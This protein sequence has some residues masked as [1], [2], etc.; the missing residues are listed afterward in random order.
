M[1]LNSEQAKGA[2][3]P[4][5]N[6]PPLPSAFSEAPELFTRLSQSEPLR[7]VVL[8]SLILNIL[9]LRLSILNKAFLKNKGVLGFLLSLQ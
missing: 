9:I 6:E 1:V 5:P 7:P 2:F 4:I 3:L 8:K